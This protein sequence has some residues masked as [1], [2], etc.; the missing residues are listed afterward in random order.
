MEE[1]ES[2]G[3][4]QGLEHD[5][6]G[7][8][9]A[10]IVKGDEKEEDNVKIA[11]KDG[12]LTGSSMVSEVETAVEAK[13]SSDISEDLFNEKNS[14]LEA[15]ILHKSSPKKLETSSD[16]PLDISLGSTT[17]GLKEESLIEF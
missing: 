14:T 4:R 2:L 15:D 5:D 7:E 16:V 9:D 11:S 6:K 13:E 17:Q 12:V 1:N 10:N 3:L 8:N